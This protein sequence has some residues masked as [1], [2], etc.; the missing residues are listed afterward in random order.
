MAQALLTHSVN[1][2][3]HYILGH[4]AIPGNE[5]S[6]HQVNIPHHAHS[7]M[8]IGRAYT[9]GSNMARQISEDRSAAKAT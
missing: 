1:T 2:E 8:A 7:N 3:I 9:S 6:D 5:E 4:S